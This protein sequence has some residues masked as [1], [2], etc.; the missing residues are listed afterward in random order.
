MK[1]KLITVLIITSMAAALC[2]CADEAP[3]AETS[4]ETADESIQSTQAEDMSE[5][6]STAVQ[7]TEAVS[8]EVTESSTESAEARFS[9]IEAGKEADGKHLIDDDLY[10]KMVITL[11]DDGNYRIKQWSSE[12]ITGMWDTYD[13]EYTLYSGESDADTGI[14]A[15]IYDIAPISGDDEGY[16]LEPE[17]ADED[18]YTLLL[19]TASDDG[20][21]ALKLRDEQISNMQGEN[22]DAVYTTMAY[23]TYDDAGS[24]ADSQS[25]NVDD[26]VWLTADEPDICGLYGVNPDDIVDDY[27]IVDNVADPFSYYIDDST[28]CSCL[29]ED[30][31][32]EAQK[33]T[34]QEFVT[35]L[36][37]RPQGRM[38]VS[39]TTNA[40]SVQEV[41][42]IYVP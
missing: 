35:M 16:L 18:Q 11:Y 22:E 8:A 28:A 32:G 26:I 34:A 41:K 38:L 17:G 40:T 27:Q 25:V 12:D 2:G 42:E 30:M 36:K 5:A 7:T 37:K 23:V 10:S 3:A 15:P 33:C 14:N 19:D 31:S 29:N 4:A 9:F 24:T 13:G 21:A 39:I 6:E 20:K 1:R